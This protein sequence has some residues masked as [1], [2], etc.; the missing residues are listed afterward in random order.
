MK[1]RS[2]SEFKFVLIDNFKINDNLAIAYLRNEIS[3]SPEDITGR[4]CD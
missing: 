2:F 3:V 4:G 1:I